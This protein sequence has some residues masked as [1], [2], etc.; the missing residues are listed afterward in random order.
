[1]GSQTQFVRPAKA[2]D[3][4]AIAQIQATTLSS[5]GVNVTPPEIEGPWAEAI[6]TQTSDQAVLVST[7]DGQ[8]TGFA[9]IAD[10]EVVA[11]EVRE[12]QRGLG[13][14]SRLLAALAEF[15]GQGELRMWLLPEQADLIR[16]LSGAGFGP[17]GQQRPV[18]GP[19]GPTTQHLWHAEV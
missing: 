4:V 6:A 11:L 10:G 7:Q 19:N 13:H 1:M 14:G 5:L 18:E 16:F 17:A 9:A 8:V 2:D 15:R 3:A 12:D